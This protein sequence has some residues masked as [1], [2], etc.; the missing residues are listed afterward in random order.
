MSH[1]QTYN[2]QHKEAGHEMMNIFPLSPTHPE[3]THFLVS[4]VVC[5]SFSF[6][7]SHFLSIISIK[8][9][10]IDIF[11]IHSERYSDFDSFFASVQQHPSENNHGNEM[12]SSLSYSTCSSSVVQIN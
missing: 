11:I 2:T 5:F 4:K 3:S 9:K 12:I 1:E 7:F 10:S 8:I 6:P